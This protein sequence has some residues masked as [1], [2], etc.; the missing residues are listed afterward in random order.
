[1][2]KHTLYLDFP[3]ERWESASP[4]GNGYTVAM[5]FGGVMTDRIQMT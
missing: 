2:D 4:V 1:M 5:I 3:A